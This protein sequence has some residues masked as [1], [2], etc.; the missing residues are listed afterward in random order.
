MCSS[1]AKKSHAKHSCWANVIVAVQAASRLFNSAG[2]RALILDNNTKHQFCDCF[3]ASAHHSLS[4]VPCQLL[5][6]RDR[7]ALM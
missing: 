7:P 4:F 6:A 5:L 1:E 3:A 2:G